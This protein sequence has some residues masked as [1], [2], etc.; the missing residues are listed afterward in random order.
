MTPPKSLPIERSAL[1]RLGTKRDLA[2]VLNVSVPSLRRLAADSN[3]REWWQTGET[4]KSR[5]IE[6]PTPALAGIQKRLHS[7]LRKVETPNWL[8]SGKRGVRPQDNALAHCGTVFVVNVDI[9]AFFQS[10]KREFVYRCFQRQFGMVDD[11]ASLLADLVTFKGHIPT[12]T[13]TSQIMAFWAYKQTFERIA[14]LCQ[15]RNIVMTLW[16][17][18]I[19]FSSQTPF[20]SNW[21]RDINKILTNVELRLKSSKTR[22][23]SVGEYKVVT[24][25]AI[26]P[27]GEILARNTKRSEI[28]SLISG[29]RVED[30]SLSEARSL[31]G[32]LAS[33]RQNES[34]FFDSMYG[35]CKAHIKRLS[36]ENR[37]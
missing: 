5:L 11:V 35:R 14:M 30:L 18:D 27:Q 16:V 19:T 17:D 10:T 3:Y 1:Y 22:R 33:Q 24:G 13:S 15:S 37:L 2:R 9:E 28:L 34:N 23:Y 12:G 25:S 36:T 29:R 20:P 21:P 4:G 7:E 32:R 6:E 8:M 31:F 26:S